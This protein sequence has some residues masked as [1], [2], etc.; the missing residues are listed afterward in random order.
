M[1]DVILIGSG[2]VGSAIAFDLNRLGLNVVVLERERELGAGASRSNSGILHT[3]FDSEVGTLETRLIRKQA[4][5]WRYIFDTLKIPYKIPGALL[6]ANNSEEAG[7]LETIQQNAATNGVE[8]QILSREETK[9][10]EPN[11]V[12]GASLHIPGEAMT[13]PFE[14]MR[15]LLADVEVRLNTTV[16]A[17]EENND[18]LIV[19]TNNERLE[20]RFVINCA[21]LFADELTNEF[22]ITPRRGEFI[23]FEKGTA[24]LVNHILLPMPNKFTKGVLVFPTLHGYLC[25]GPSAEDQDD[26]HDWTPHQNVLP[27]LYEKAAQMLPKLKA[28]QPVNA[29][30]GLRTVGHPRNYFIEF[31]KH[32]PNLLHVAGIRST[33]L[34]A[35]LGIS[36]Y[37]V[38]LLKEKGLES[39]PSTPSFAIANFH[40]FKPWWERLNALRN[41]DATV[42]PRKEL[43]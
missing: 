14:V 42:L 23:V 26:K 32:F 40:D 4:E 21:G 36:D 34:S 10:L 16:Q 31:S 28:L 1:R 3:G 15:R 2:L 24:N 12:A 11:A 18:N 22:Q 8:T 17:V 43:K 30:A 6:L 19:I 35:C 7:K 29:W 33:G 9:R 39:K 5:R 37:V 25:A 27:T 38:N 13:D 41:V 20:S